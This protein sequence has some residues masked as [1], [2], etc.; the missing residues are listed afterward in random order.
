VGNSNS[1]IIRAHQTSK[2]FSSGHLAMVTVAVASCLITSNAP[3][4]GPCGHVYESLPTTTE[5]CYSSHCCTQT[6]PPGGSTRLG[7]ES[8]IWFVW[9]VLG[10]NMP[11][12]AAMFTSLR[13]LLVKHVTPHV[14]SLHSS[15]CQTLKSAILNIAFQLVPSLSAQVGV[16]LFS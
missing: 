4:A 16:C 5:A 15:Q 8:D 13:R 6:D 14:V 3:V 10:V 11:D 2:L 9:C 1:S 12:H 7:V